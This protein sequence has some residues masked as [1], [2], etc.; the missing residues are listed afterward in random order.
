[1]VKKNA[2]REGMG[3]KRFKG[4]KRDFQLTRT[5]EKSVRGGTFSKWRQTQT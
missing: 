3:D 5:N 2:G 4:G 1:L